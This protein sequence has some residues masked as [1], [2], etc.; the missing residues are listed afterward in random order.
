DVLYVGDGALHVDRGLVLGAERAEP[1]F[2][3]RPSTL[4]PEFFDQQLAPP[5]VPSPGELDDR[6]LELANRR[7]FGRLGDETEMEARGITLA[8]R[9]IVINQCAA[10]ARGE[11][12]LNA[13]ADLGGKRF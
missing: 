11:G 5:I 6:R 9:E 4:L 3:E 12:V 7:C 1:F 8:E 13:A 2:R 10:Q